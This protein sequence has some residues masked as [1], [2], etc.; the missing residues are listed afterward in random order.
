MKSCISLYSYW[1]LVMAKKMTHYQVIDT[2]KSLGIDAVEIQIF[3][4]AVPKD[5]TM[6]EYAKALCN[7]AREIGLEVPIFT[8]DSKIYCPDPEQEL[9][10]L[11]SLV[12][13]AAELGIP[14]MR[15]DIAYKFL[16]NES[17]KSP[18]KIIDTIVPYIRRLAD[19]A[20]ERGVKVCSENHGRIMQDS[21]RMEELF[22][23][24]D[25]KN[26]GLLCDI[27]NFGG[28]D[29]DCAQAVS[30]LLPHIC[31]VH[32]K[33]SFTRSGMIYD[34]G[35][36]FNRTRGGSFRRSTIFG[37]GDVPTYQIL[38]A[39]KKSGYDGYVS[40]EFEG[41]EET[42]MA[43]EIGAENLKRMLSDIDK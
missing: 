30:R 18:K 29:E 32:A 12:D 5:M 33:D 27:G 9:A 38:T 39:I 43:V 22:Y 11:C 17:T 15:F 10:H 24:V 4:P 23:Q 2:I 3:D 7:Y 34:P 41:I 28:A 42:K 6:G 14:L 16:G 1:P 35:R 8:V 25:H 36:G 21:Y 37:H 31:F 20:E 40:I 13:V 26:Y 19:Y